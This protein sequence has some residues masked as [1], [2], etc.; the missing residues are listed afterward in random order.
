MKKSVLSLITVAALLFSAMAGAKDSCRLSSLLSDEPALEL[1]NGI[2]DA[3]T[4]KKDYCLN[5][6]LHP[7][8]DF[9][10]PAHGDGFYRARRA[11][12]PVYSKS[13]IANSTYIKINLKLKPPF[14]VPKSQTFKVQICRSGKVTFLDKNPYF[15]SLESH[16]NTGGKDLGLEGEDILGL[17]QLNF[18]MEDAP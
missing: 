12:G 13:D 6:F 5:Y 2:L 18:F 7:P 9:K 15:G 1:A 11:G 4:P 14:T 16:G 3:Q 17:L 8:Y 10:I